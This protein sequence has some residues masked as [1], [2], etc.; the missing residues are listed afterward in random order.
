MF[1]PALLSRALRVE[2]FATLQPCSS[3][4]NVQA[5]YGGGPPSAAVFPSLITTSNLQECEPSRM[6]TE[7]NVFTRI[8]MSML[9]I[10]DK[11]ATFSLLIKVRTV[12]VECFATLQPCSSLLNVQVFIVSLCRCC[13]TAGR[14][15]APGRCLRLA[16]KPLRSF[17]LAVGSN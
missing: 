11:I 16:R 2:C 14:F 1:S 9:R 15:A 4:R 17:D 7:T 10:I 6:R 5:A 13:A 3:L 8:E 12:R